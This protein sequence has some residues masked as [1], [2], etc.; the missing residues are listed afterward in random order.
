[1]GADSAEPDDITVGRRV[2]DAL[3]ADLPAARRDVLHDHLLPHDFAHARGHDATEHV[4]RASGSERND[5]RDRSCRVGLR[6]SAAGT[7]EQARKNCGKL[8]SKHG[9][10][11]VLSTG[12]RLL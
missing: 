10:P 3:R 6:I 8:E 1:M 9:N 7:R 5:Q 4:G 12:R 11:V 2:R